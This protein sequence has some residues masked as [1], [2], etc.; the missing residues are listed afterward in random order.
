LRK[1][2]A[3]YF[4]IIHEQTDRG[5][6]YAEE[7]IKYVTDH[8][9]VNALS[10][11]HFRYP[12][13]DIFGFRFIDICFLRHPL[14]RLQSMY[15]HYKRD[16][17]DTEKSIR[18]KTMALAEWLKWLLETEPYNSMNPQT[19]F[20][21]LGGSYFFPPTNSHLATA[22]KRV[23]EVRFLGLVD[24][25]DESLATA[26]FFLRPIFP[27]LDLSYIAQNVSESWKAGLIEKLE[28]MKSECGE[29][30]FDRLSK[31]N[32]IDERLWRYAT[33]ELERRLQY[34]PN[35]EQ[36][37]NEVNVNPNMRLS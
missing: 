34:V 3:D 11:H 1:N 18:A 2:F 26:E 4:N 6:L 13:P 29:S 33:A 8:P 28:K 25:F 19:C 12:R 32:E 35:I 36:K 5:T 17:E 31:L 30:F 9:E 14:D 27:K 37:C 7:I 21:A 23:S 22:I 10:S 15:L 16:S 24:R 20:M